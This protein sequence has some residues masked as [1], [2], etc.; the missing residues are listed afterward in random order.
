[1]LINSRNI[2]AVLIFCICAAFAQDETM[3]RQDLAHSG[4]Y[5]SAAPEGISHV[6]WKFKTAGRVFSSPVV[7]EGVLYTGSN[8]HYIHAID[9]RK[10][11]E[12]WKF[13][14][15][16][17]VTSTPAISPGSLFVL[18]LDGN[19]YCL[20]TRTG[21]LKWKFKTGGESRMSA[22][23]L[24]G[25]EPSGEVT[26]DVWDFFLSSPAVDDGRVYFGSGDHYIYALGAN[27]G[28]LVWKYEASDVVHSSPAIANGKLYIGCWDGTLYALN[29]K[30]GH[31]VWKVQ[32]GKDPSRFMEGIP[33][34]VAIAN[35]VLVFGSRDNNIYAFDAN[36]GK[37]LWKQS[38]DG[39]WVISSPAIENNTVYMTTSDSMKFRALELQTGKPIFDI[40][41]KAYSFSSPAIASGHAYFGT[42]DGMVYDI[43]LAGRRINSQFQ[44]QAARDH[45]E[46][47]TQDGHLN[48]DV[49]YGPLGPDGK[50]NNTL[51][52][53]VVGVDRLLQL[54]GILSSPSVFDG[55][56][57]VGS[58]DGN[59]YALH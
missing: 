13:E 26:P 30:D 5:S 15:G 18:S 43:D 50:P 55:I 57:Y 8:D 33:G 11:S 46:L 58:M 36:S 12:L 6:L 2:L 35:G 24:Y 51:D 7:A 47:L 32:T 37:Q 25:L 31:L 40:G 20:D 29:A 9:A 16:A 45:K 38:N 41:Y 39:S 17:N 27:T 3:F 19:A 22:P 42:F 59:I 34:S 54:G 49:I 52:A 44:V 10:G 48:A 21:K 4:V 1:M 14:T 53:N 28:Q 56:V 23:G